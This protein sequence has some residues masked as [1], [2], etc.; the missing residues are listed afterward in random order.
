[1]IKC[2]GF[3]I[4]KTTLFLIGLSLIVWRSYECLQKHLHESLG[5]RV[6][7]VKSYETIIPSL[8]LCPAYLEA[9][10]LREVNSIIIFIIFKRI[11]CLHKQA[12]LIRLATDLY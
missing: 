12:D 5:T 11:Y 4:L 8:T 1:M 3:T 2:D 7:M 10:N 9:Y 6:A